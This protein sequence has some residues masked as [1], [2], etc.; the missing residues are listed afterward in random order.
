[1]GLVRG[2]SCYSKHGEVNLRPYQAD[3]GDIVTLIFSM[4]KN[5][6]IESALCEGALL[7]CRIHVFGTIYFLFIIQIALLW[8]NIWFLCIMQI[9]LIRPSIWFPSTNLLF[10]DHL[11]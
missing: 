8:H 10:S 4:S 1:M 5:C 6:L 11:N 3:A 7:E 9:L 2:D